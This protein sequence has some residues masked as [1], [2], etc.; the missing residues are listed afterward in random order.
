M[1]FRYR[2]YDE[3]QQLMNRHFK[4]S[5]ARGDWLN[6]VDMIQWEHEYFGNDIVFDGD[7]RP[8]IERIETQHG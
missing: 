8:V 3:Q 4:T 7:S 6:T 1:N 2:S 5:L